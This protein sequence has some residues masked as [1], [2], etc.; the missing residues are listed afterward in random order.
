L[1]IRRLKIPSSI[2]RDGKPIIGG[3]DINPTDAGFAARIYPKPGH[4][5][6][7]ASASAPVHVQ[8]VETD[9][10]DESEDVPLSSVGRGRLGETRW[11]V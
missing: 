9:D 10:W 5:A 7:A 8:H 3:I 11:G 6:I 4:Q 2:T 1:Q